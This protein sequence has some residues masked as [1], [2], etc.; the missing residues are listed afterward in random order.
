MGIP[1]TVVTAG[2]IAVTEA[3]NGLGLAVTPVAAGGLAVVSVLNG[4]L[5]VTGLDA[6]SN[7]APNY[8]M[9]ALAGSFIFTGEQMTVQAGFAMTAQ[10]GAFALAGQSANLVP[11]AAA[12]TGPGE[13]T[14]WDTAYG[15]WG[16][17]GYTFAKVGSNCLDVCSNATG[18][19]INLTT[20]VIGSDGYVN[21]SGIGFSPI[22]V[23]KIWDQAGTQ[24]VSFLLDSTRP[25]L[26]LSAVGGKPAMNFSGTGT[27]FNSVSN[28]TVQAQ[29]VTVAAVA[30]TGTYDTP[31][32]AFVASAGGFGSLR[33]GG[34]NLIGQYLGGG[35]VSSYALTDGTFAS[36]ISVCNSTSSS[37]SVNGTIGSSGADVGSTGITNATKLTIS[38][39]DTGGSVWEGSIFEIIVKAGSVSPTNQGLLTAN[40]R[41]IGTG[42]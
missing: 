9:R 4:G 7:V 19:A 15:Y 28:A 21:L 22:Y 23:N 2:G 37:M 42:F 20:V 30:K 1:V 11:P 6:G 13:I 32:Q 27:H 26:T 38:G 16:L 35:A 8:R 18:A 34:A 12:Y 36:L 24:D 39:T 25:V 41:A 40:Q 29:P 3:L 5:P 17:R 33:H 31:R 14:G 10:V